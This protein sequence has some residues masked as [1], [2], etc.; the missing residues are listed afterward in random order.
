MVVFEVVLEPA[1]VE[2]VVVVAVRAVMVTSDCAA[3]ERAEVVLKRAE[4]VVVVVEN[5]ELNVVRAEVRMLRPTAPK[6]PRYIL[7]VVIIVDVG[8]VWGGV[9]GM[10]GLG[11]CGV[12]GVIIVVELISL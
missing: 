3:V 6:K 12:R 10:G 8:L 7:K 4:V 1:E 2:V 9:V 11:G 5:W